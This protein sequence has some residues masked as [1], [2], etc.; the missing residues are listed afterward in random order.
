[1][2]MQPEARERE[3]LR[4]LKSHYENRGYSFVVHPSASIVPDF[5]KGHTPDA[6]ALK[7]LGGVVVEVVSDRGVA[8]HRL[9]A[10][11]KRFEGQRDWK[12][13]VVTA[14]T[15]DTFVPTITR[16][17]ILAELEHICDLSAAGERRAGFLMAWAALEATA[18]MLLKRAGHSTDKALVA[19]QIAE[20]L[21]RH[22]FIDQTTSDQL[23]ALIAARNS[24]AHGDLRRVVSRGDVDQVV[25]LVRE[26]LSQEKP[27]PATAAPT[28]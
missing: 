21:T 8:T 13:E 27:E 6:L 12:L 4:M 2:K 10:L 26:L 23:R 25:S 5:L 20:L 15:A 28:G 3:I 9:Q 7:D 1:M 14:S 16:D 11:A 18:R 24:V 19:E 17:E 22:G